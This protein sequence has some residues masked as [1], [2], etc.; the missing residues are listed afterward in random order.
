MQPRCLWAWEPGSSGWFVL[1]VALSECDYQGPPRV[2]CDLFSSLLPRKR[3]LWETVSRSGSLRAR[4]ISWRWSAEQSKLLSSYDDTNSIS[5]VCQMER[6]FCAHA[7]RRS[8]NGQLVVSHKLRFRGRKGKIS[9][10]WFWTSSR[11]V[12]CGLSCSPSGPFSLI[13]NAGR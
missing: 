13:C 2:L 7:V 6:H 8:C 5:L 12:P 3:S 1:W 11:R 4:L 10:R 9:S